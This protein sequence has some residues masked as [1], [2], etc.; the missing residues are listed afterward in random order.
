MRRSLCVVG[1]TLLLTAL[2]EGS[3][4]RHLARK[5]LKKPSTPPLKKPFPS[6]KSDA[7]GKVIYIFVLICFNWIEKDFIDMVIGHLSQNKC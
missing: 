5:Q 6:L 1:L 2:T 3:A 7:T 4:F